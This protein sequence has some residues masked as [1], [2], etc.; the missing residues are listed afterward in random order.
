MIETMA[1]QSKFKDF[2]L[3]RTIATTATGVK[4]YKDLTT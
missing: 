2:Y 3:V 1:H 4:R